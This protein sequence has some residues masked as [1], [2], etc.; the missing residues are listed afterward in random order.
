MTDLAVIPSTDQLDQYADAGRFVELACERAKDWLR[1]ALERGDIEGIVD[2]KSQAEAIRT[3][4]VQ[5]QLGKDAELSAA[6]IVRRA[7]R[8]IGLAIRK[9]QEAGEFRKQGE[10]SRF[11]LG[12]DATKNSP[13][14]VFSHHGER[15]DVYAVTDGVSDEQF[16][17]AIDEARDEGN[18]SR[19]N[20]VKKVAQVKEASVPN[21]LDGSR[22]GVELRVATARQMAA[23]GATSKQIAKRIG[24]AKESMHAFR[25]RHG[26]DVPA[27]RIV[28]R[29]SDI[30][31]NRVIGATVD[32]LRNVDTGLHLVEWDELDL[33]QFPDWIS[34][35]KEARKSITTLINNLEKEKTSRDSE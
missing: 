16:D 7:E 6:E 27:D 21:V 30:D 12:P 11:V 4:T 33:E 15:A 34:V 22:A 5:K 32:S 35:L 29:T 31:S 24:I 14:D 28:G 17:E 9:G 19:A 23:E 25:T 20:V 3:Y 13:S 18:L 1:Q 26:I 8:G 2:L 10:T